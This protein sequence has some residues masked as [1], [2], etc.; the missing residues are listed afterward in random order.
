MSFGMVPFASPTRP[1]GFIRA[2]KAVLA[3][4]GTC[5]RQAGNYKLQVPNNKQTP[6]S[7]KRNPKRI[8]SIIGIWI[9][10][11][12][13]NL[14]FEFCNLISVQKMQ[15]IAR[16]YLFGQVRAGTVRYGQA[17]GDG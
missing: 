8:V 10:E 6:N 5:P 16:L 11:F 9:L 1:N 15:E 17:G 2:G 3:G 14:G 13:C 4:T 12:I 7:N